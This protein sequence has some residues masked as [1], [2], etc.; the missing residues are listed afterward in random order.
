MSRRRFTAGT[1]LVILLVAGVLSHAASGSPDG[2]TYVAQLH[3]FAGS[4]TPS[5]VASGPLAGYSLDGVAGSRLAGSAA[6]LLGCAACFA[7][8]LVALRRRPGGAL[9]SAEV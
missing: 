7:L 4:E 1:V 6:G 3:G 5:A 9:T 2:L 8:V